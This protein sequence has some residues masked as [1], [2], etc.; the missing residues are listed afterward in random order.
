MKHLEFSSIIETTEFI[1]T[2]A[3]G[4]FYTL[5]GTISY[6][7]N[8]LEIDFSSISGDLKSGAR[9]SFDFTFVH[10]S[11]SGNDGTVS[12]SQAAT[13]ISTIFTLSQDFY[14]ST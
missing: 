3:Q 5:D 13:N 7:N 10:N 9:L 2:L 6:A 1:S 11:F 4:V 8:K 14:I 12:T